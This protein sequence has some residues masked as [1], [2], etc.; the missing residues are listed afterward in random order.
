MVW[1]FLLVI[2]A[3]IIGLVITGSN[4]YKPPKNTWRSG[5][6]SGEEAEF[7][8]EAAKLADKGLNAKRSKT[9]EEAL[10]HYE[11]LHDDISS[12]RKL[13]SEHI[14]Q[15]DMR[16]IREIYED[17]SIEEWQNRARKILDKFYALY[18]MI[19]DPSFKDVDKA[20]RS[21]KRCIEYWQ[22]YFASIPY[23]THI[24]Y[25]AKTYMKEYLGDGYDDCMYTHETLE[26]KLARCI[27][28]MKPE[29]KRKMKLRDQI[30]NVVAKRESVT[31]AE[32]ASMPFDGCTKQEVEYCIRELVENYRLVALKISNR[33][34]VS[35]SDREKEKRKGRQ[36]SE[37]DIVKEPLPKTTYN[38]ATELVGALRGSGIECTITKTNDGYVIHSSPAVDGF[39]QNAALRVGLLQKV[40]Y[41]GSHMWILQTEV[42]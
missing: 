31:R 39:M 42:R 32:L 25:D 34:F 28:E 2:S 33:Y 38:D 13:V 16:Y 6:M 12:R 26:K 19:T 10:I 11:L 5:R 3:M 17:L 41:Y 4:S 30:I 37:H 36:S 29:Y 20:Y 35:L 18:E 8:R 21:K 40:P 27:E 24:W 9:A 23:E 14:Y 22:E 15:E 1:I 7:A